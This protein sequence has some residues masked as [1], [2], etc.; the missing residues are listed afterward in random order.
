MKFF[1]D[2]ADVGEIREALSWGLIDGITTNPSLLA[3]TG[4]PYAEGF[5]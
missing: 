3:K 5:R 1:L 4:R 2:G